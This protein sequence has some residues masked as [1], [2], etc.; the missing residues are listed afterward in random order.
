M[1]YGILTDNN[2]LGFYQSERRCEV[3]YAIGS[4][5]VTDEVVYGFGGWYSSD[6][7]TF[8]LMR[9]EL[10]K[11]IQKN[12]IMLGSDTRNPSWNNELGLLVPE[13]AI[14][15]GSQSGGGW[16]VVG[17]LNFS[18]YLNTPSGGRRYPVWSENADTLVMYFLVSTARESTWRASTGSVTDTIYVMVTGEL[19]ENG[20]QDI[21]EYGFIMKNSLGDI[22]FN[23]NYMP[24]N[25]SGFLS[26][27]SVPSNYKSTPAF[28]AT[29]LNGILMHPVVN[30]GHGVGS[31]GWNANIGIC[32][33]PS[34]ISYGARVNG[35]AG[36]F[37][38]SRSYAHLSSS[39]EFP[40]YQ[41]SQYF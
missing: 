24:L 21:P 30:I 2:F 17:G 33:S 9:V 15:S 29:N 23:S 32:M 36:T 35:F 31:N 19:P 28:S 12:M 18:D 14:V 39:A 37:P 7:P 3:V 34:G 4:A 16:G 25:P 5:T 20:T 27:P 10:E 13:V 38:Q 22:T 6:R 11:L 8:L 41:A 1:S 40:V 26:Y